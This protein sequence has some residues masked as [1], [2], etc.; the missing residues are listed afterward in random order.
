MNILILGNTAGLT[1]DFILKTF[2][3]QAVFIFGHT[4]VK[5]SRKNKITVFTKH[6]ENNQ[7][8][9]IF[10]FHDYD[11]IIYLS[12]YL[13]Y[14][15]ESSGEIE[16]LIRL[17]KCL[18]A[19]I[20][21]RLLYITGPILQGGT[22]SLQ[23]T[24]K[25]TF[26]SWAKEFGVNFKVLHSPFLYSLI[27][28]EDYLFKLFERMDDHEQVELKE[29]SQSQATFISLSDLGDLLHKLCERWSDKYESIV[30][31]D[32]FQLTFG[33]LLQ[34]LD[35]YFPNKQ[36]RFLEEKA[37]KT[38]DNHP[39]KYHDLR[40]KFAWFMRYA[41]VR[42][43]P[44]I[45][46]DYQRQRK[47]SLR[48]SKLRNLLGN[49]VKQKRN[50][51]LAGVVVTFLVF[52]AFRHMTQGQLQFQLIDLRLL[53][54]VLIST[55]LGM[56]YGLFSSVL[57]IIGLTV[58]QIL[59]GTSWQLLLYNTDRW[60]AFIAYIFIAVVCGF[61]EMKK[62]DDK[63]QL[64][65]QLETVKED[66]LILNQSY[67]TLLHENK[68]LKN[69]LLAS[70]NGLGKAYSY[71]VSLDHD[72][73]EQVLRKTL[74][75]VSDILKS[76]V[77]LYGGGPI[78]YELLLGDNDKKQVTL[79]DFK[80]ISDAFR[81][82]RVWANKS[83]L[84]NRPAYAMEIKTIVGATF[85]IWVE[86]VPFEVMSTKVLNELEVLSK[87]SHS[88]IEKAEFIEEASREGRIAQ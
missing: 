63:L 46:E 59:S 41:L 48:V 31:P 4:G 19:K 54:V 49:I 5:N 70:Q 38:Y 20:N 58:S 76:P 18:Q 45:Y 6:Y 7:L 44:D 43:L 83:L 81:Q 79:T 77:S 62:K 53:F 88:F 26:R 11:Q 35:K 61:V 57:A 30:I 34:A 69:T 47:G 51:K 33:E 14:G 85:I 28:K 8:E 2:P 87:M 86:T 42:D 16:N 29:S 67:D 75:L 55:V 40:D 64:D 80:E 52:E 60:V 36:V 66:Y 12:E 9:D 22:R 3:N 24:T 82:G 23:T 68:D 72:S 65:K 37:I 15:H 10:E 71:F 25:E 50:K 13:N 27:N 17:L 73:A 84:E 21:T 1:N 74:D 56:G 39:D 78:H 32:P